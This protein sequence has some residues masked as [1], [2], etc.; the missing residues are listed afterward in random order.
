MSLGVRNSRAILWEPAKLDQSHLPCGSNPNVRGIKVQ[1]SRSMRK[2]STSHRQQEFRPWFY[3]QTNKDNSHSHLPRN[4]RLSHAQ[5]PLSMDE[6]SFMCSSC[7]GSPPRIPCFAAGCD[8]GGQVLISVAK[9][10][11]SEITLDISA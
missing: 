4:Y 8:P 7:A 10:R 1:N 3:I 2:I 11:L 5:A 6:T 9:H